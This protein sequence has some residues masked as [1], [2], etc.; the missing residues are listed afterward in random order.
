MIRN[1]K[2][3]VIYTAGYPNFAVKKLLHLLSGQ[4]EQIHHWGDS[5]FDGLRIAEIINNI[6]KVKLWR[7]TVE[8]CK[9]Y[10]GRLKPADDNS[11][12]KIKKFLENKPDFIF[13][14]ELEYSLKNG[15]LEQEVWSK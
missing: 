10:N 2:I 8:D 14:D 4:I 12:S 1:E 11:K 6:I 7:C 3:P 5:D 9:K 13:R 15:W